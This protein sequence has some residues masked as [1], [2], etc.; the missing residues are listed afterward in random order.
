MTRGG[1][2]VTAVAY[3]PIVV[4]RRLGAML[5]KLRAELGLHLD[6]VARRLEISPSKLSRL[7][8][9]Q[10]TPKTRDVRDLL[11]IYDAPAEIRERVMRWTTE[12]KE[13]GWWQPYS[14]GIPADLDLY[15]SL[16]AEA[17]RIQMFSIPVSGLLQTEAYA[18]MVLGGGVPDCSPAELDRLVEIRIGRQ[19]VLA[20]DRGNV[21]PVQLHAVL[22]EA[23]LRR[24]SDPA[25]LRDQ[26]HTLIDRSRWPNVIVQVLPFTVGFTRASSTFAIFEPREPGDDEVVNVESTG[27]DAYFDT[28]GKVAEYRAI[29]DDVLRHALEPD[30]SRELL[31]RLAAG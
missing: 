30:R 16:E 12:A 24:G 31:S 7:E 18:R 22:D 17:T 25:V 4:R 2:P 5:K 14:D 15:I 27:H 21:P 26:L 11:E 29:W 3:G 9:G 20:P 1:I 19:A 10:V 23:A 13:P 28:A 8:T 6:V